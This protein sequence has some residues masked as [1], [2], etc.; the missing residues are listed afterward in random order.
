MFRRVRKTPLTAKAV[1][2][3]R[4]GLLSVP[5]ATLADF[6]FRLALEPTGDDV[7]TPIGGTAPPDPAAKTAAATMRLE[8]ITYAAAASVIETCVTYAS[9]F[10]WFVNSH[11]RRLKAPLPPPLLV[12]ATAKINDPDALQLWS[13]QTREDG[14]KPGYGLQSVFLPRDAAEGDPRVEMLARC[15]PSWFAAMYASCENNAQLELGRC[16]STRD[17]H[18]QRCVRSATCRRQGTHTLAGS[19]PCVLPRISP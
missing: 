3:P 1:D 17:H 9:N 10:S 2:A 16:C 12:K 7:L 11:T 8:E 18:S 15:A 4:S 6:G 5:P 14:T 13:E 19:C